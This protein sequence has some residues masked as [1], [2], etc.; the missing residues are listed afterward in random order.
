MDTKKYIESTETETIGKTTYFKVKDIT[1]LITAFKK[2]DLPKE[3]DA[4]RIIIGPFKFWRWCS[5]K[6]YDI[7]IKRAFLIIKE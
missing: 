7:L 1:N 4:V 6:S 2:S 5:A 3:Y